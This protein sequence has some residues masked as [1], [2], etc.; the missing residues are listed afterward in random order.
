VLVTTLVIAALFN[1]LRLRIQALI[2]RRFFRQ[3]YSAEQALA[4]FALAAREGSDLDLLSASL[5]EL[6]L[7]TLQPT[8]VNLIFSTWKGDQDWVDQKIKKP[9]V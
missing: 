9:L 3:K 2:D 5:T 4:E 7:R 6:V 8:E 1:P